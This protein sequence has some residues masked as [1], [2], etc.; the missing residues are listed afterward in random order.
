MLQDFPQSVPVVCS[1]S[2]DHIPFLLSMQEI[3]LEDGN[4]N[5][6]EALEGLQLT[7]CFTPESRHRPRKPA[8]KSSL[9]SC[10]MTSLAGNTYFRTFIC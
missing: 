1:S 6:S 3:R 7:T 5:V 9:M 2:L 10:V 4:C 8:E